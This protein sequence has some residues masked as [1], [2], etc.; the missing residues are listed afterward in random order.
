M[1]LVCSEELPM[2]AN[3]LRPLVLVSDIT[4][5]HSTQTLDHT[6]G[7]NARLDERRKVVVN[8]AQK[9]LR[10]IG[11]S[12]SLPTAIAAATVALISM[13]ALFL[14]HHAGWTLYYGDAEAHL[15]HARRIW[16]SQTPGWEQLG[17][18]WLPLPH[19]LMLPFVAN[20]SL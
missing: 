1:G 6:V 3:D 18:V 5:S 15:N 19:L 2:V 8:Y 12:S 9:V 13:A 17:T 16:D 10:L 7:V 14:T 4:Y 20:R 11:T